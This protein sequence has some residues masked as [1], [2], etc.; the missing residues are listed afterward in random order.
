MPTPLLIALAVVLGAVTLTSGIWVPLLYWLRRRR[1]ERRF[2]SLAVAL[3]ATRQGDHLVVPTLELGAVVRLHPPSRNTP[4]VLEV[5]IPAQGEARGGPAILLRREGLLDRIGKRLG[6]NREVQIGDALFD[7]AVYIESDAPDG[8]V[9]W[10]LDHPGRRGAVL[11]IL[12]AGFSELRVH[13]DGSLLSALRSRPGP[14]HLQADTIRTVARSLALLAP[15]IPA[16][17]APGAGEG[18]PGRARANAVALAILGG[19]VL[20]LGAPG[21]MIVLRDAYPPVTGDLYE[22]ALPVAGGLYL[23]AVIVLGLVVRGHSDSLRVFLLLAGVLLFLLPCY[24]VSAFVGINGALDGATPARHPSRI[25]ERSVT[26]G[27]NPTCHLRFAGL[28]RGEE[29]VEVKLP[30]ARCDAF[31]Q[32]DAITV[33]TGAGALG[34][35]W[36]ERVEAVRKR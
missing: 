20:I 24:T 13:E 36:I 28:R 17:E 9:R 2:Q 29:A 30:V 19:L 31:A 22:V 18:P 7:R 23:A 34:W 26:H 35:E 12:A 4:Y 5:A 3:G 21:L 25:L 16:S 27:K 6:L 10:L 32:G 15:A 8:V 1:V 11:A 14:A 33:S